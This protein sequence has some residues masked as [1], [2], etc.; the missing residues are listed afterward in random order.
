MKSFFQRTLLLLCSLLLVFLPSCI[1]MPGDG[2]EE[3]TVR[4]LTWAAGTSFPRAEDFVTDLP[5]GFKA[6]FA[7][8]YDFSSVGTY[9]VEIT[10]TNDK[11]KEQSYEATLSMIVDT[12]PPRVNGVKDLQAYIGDG[13]AYRTGISTA[14]NC[15]GAVRLDVDSSAVNLQR[16]GSY[17]VFYIA[18]DAAGNQSRVQTTLYL[19]LERITEEKLYELLDPIIRSAIPTSGSLESQ[20]RAVYHYVYFQTQY[21]STS[22]KND[23]IRAAYDGLRK[24]EGDCYTYF[25]ISKAFFER[26]G[27]ENMDIQRTQGL[28]DERHY[29]NYVNIGT[30]DS[31]AWYHFDA[32]RLLGAT[33]SGCLLT[34]IQVGAYTKMRESELGERNYFYAYDH[35]KYPASA[36]AIITPTPGLEPYY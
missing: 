15:N 9:Q 21:T 17:P 32:C 8:A 16:E 27:I 6:S 19:Y 12:E 35:S 25:A 23:W 30:K 20:V 29:W 22:D 13:I 36:T 5:E 11:G 7:R 1:K 24:G 10:V 3:I 14:D 18:T 2:F 26:L 28:V 33:H 31:P 34:D 4:N